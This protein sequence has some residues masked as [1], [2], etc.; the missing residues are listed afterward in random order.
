MRKTWIS[1]W[2]SRNKLFH[3]ISLIT[4]SFIFIFIPI[5]ISISIFILIFFLFL[6][7]SLFFFLF[8]FFD[9]YSVL[10]LTSIKGPHIPNEARDSRA[11]IDLIA[12]VDQSG[13]MMY[14][15]LERFQMERNLYL[16]HYRGQKLELVL[17]TMKF[18][19]EQ[20]KEADQLCIISYPP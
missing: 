8:C 20:L 16:L 11:P 1:L 19:V 12:I 15:I 13:S 14:V 4:V 7:Y 18:V 6:I 17:H 10:L 2:S 5:S 9:G 3:L